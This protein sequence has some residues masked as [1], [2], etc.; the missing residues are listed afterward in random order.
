MVCRM[1]RARK[2]KG[3]ERTRGKE[4]TQKEH[5]NNGWPC[6]YSRGGQKRAYLVKGAKQ[7]QFNV[8]NKNGP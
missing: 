4:F 7:K 6:W 5:L 2:I 3:E 1:V 8:S